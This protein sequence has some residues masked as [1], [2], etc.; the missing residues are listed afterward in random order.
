M[1]YN[2]KRI[3]E[4]FMPITLRTVCFLSYQIN[5]KYMSEVYDILS[6]LLDTSLRLLEPDDN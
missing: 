6:F 3:P 2:T 5:F 4:L 1:D